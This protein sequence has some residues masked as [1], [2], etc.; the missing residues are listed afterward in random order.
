MA[1]PRGQEDGSEETVAVAGRDKEEE[2]PRLGVVHHQIG[3]DGGQKRC[4]AQSR[5]HVEEE[6]TG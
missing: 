1:E 4:H 5:K 3:F 2:P 6:D